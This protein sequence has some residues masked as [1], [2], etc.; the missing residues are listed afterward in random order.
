M[1][2]LRLTD[3]PGAEAS[4]V[5][6]TVSWPAS[7]MSWRV[8]TL[9]DCGVSRADSCRPVAVPVEPLV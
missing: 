8:I 5:C 7:S 1:L 9:T 6:E 4:S 3:R 2:S